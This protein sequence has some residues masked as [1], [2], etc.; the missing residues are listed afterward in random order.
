MP[1]T[2]L[3]ALIAFGAVLWLNRRNAPSAVAL[4]AARE[5]LGVSASASEAE[6]RAAHR[7]LIG[8]VHPDVGGSA[9]MAGRVNAARDLLVTELNRKGA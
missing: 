6:I 9:A 7:R 2:L 4:R 8:Q 1:V 5:L 3:V